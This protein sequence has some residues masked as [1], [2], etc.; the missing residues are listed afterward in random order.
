MYTISITYSLIWELKTHPEYKWTKCGRCF[1]VKTGRELKKV[2]QGG[3]IGYNIKGKFK[4]INTL[5]KELVKIQPTTI[6]F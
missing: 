3:S 2:S 4:S 5:R 1:N 6:P